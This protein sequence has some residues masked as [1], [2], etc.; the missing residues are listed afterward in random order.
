MSVVNEG[1]F[2]TVEPE[3]IEHSK[4][5][6]WQFTR[7]SGSTVRGSIKDLSFCEDGT[8]M[9]LLE[10]EACRMVN[11]GV[12]ARTMVFYIISNNLTVMSSGNGM[13]F[14][15][16]AMNDIIS[17]LATEITECDRE[18]S[19]LYEEVLDPHNVGH[20]VVL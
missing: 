20:D 18:E 5:R 13:I 17:S 3:S 2:I 12:L 4:H 19:A 15:E 6:R 10:S 7:L 14:V 16:H 8:Y 11:V 9:D 1:N